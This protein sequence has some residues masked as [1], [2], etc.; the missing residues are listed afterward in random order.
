MTADN[1]LAVKFVVFIDICRFYGR[2]E[3]SRAHKIFWVMNGVFWMD[4]LWSATKATLWV[5]GMHWQKWNKI[6]KFK[7]D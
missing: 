4:S 6:A 7:W 3:R 2:H 5:V 1:L